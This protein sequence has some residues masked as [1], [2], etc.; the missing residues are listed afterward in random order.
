[1]TTIYAQRRNALSTYLAEQKI[2]V[3]MITD[4]A[5]IFY[6][7]GFPSEPHERFLSLVIDTKQD[8][9]FYSFPL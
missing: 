3:A 7:T 8:D 5:N 9:T 4:P 6:Y 1:M 2:D